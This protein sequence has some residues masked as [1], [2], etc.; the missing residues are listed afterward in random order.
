MGQEPRILVL[1]QGYPISALVDDI[2]TS[3]SDSVVIDARFSDQLKSEADFRLVLHFARDAGKRI[4][5]ITRDPVVTALAGQLGVDVLS[6]LQEQKVVEPDDGAEE[7]AA[8]SDHEEEPG[9]Q[10]E[11]AGEG[12][13]DEA[14]EGVRE[15]AEIR[16]GGAMVGGRG[17][18]RRALIVAAALA[19]VAAGV[20]LVYVL[21]LRVGVTVIPATVNISETVIIA[22][23]PTGRQLGESDVTIGITVPSEVLS[24]EVEYSTEIPTTGE[25]REGITPSVGEVLLINSSL[26]PVTVPARTRL[27]T[28]DGIE[29]ETVNDVTVDPKTITMRAGLKVGEIN[30]TAVVAATACNPGS[31][32]N[33]PAMSIA[34]IKGPLAGRLQVVNEHEFR[35]GRDRVT[36]VVSEADV[37]RLMQI[38]ERWMLEDGAARLR[39]MAGLDRYL[40]TPTLELHIRSSRVYPDALTESDRVS[41]D[42]EG[43]VDLAS[44][45]FRDLSAAIEDKLSAAMGDGFRL[46]ADQL[47][48]DSLSCARLSSGIV[49]ISVDANAAFVAE[50]DGRL[51]AAA[52]AGEPVEDARRRLL[53]SGEVAEFVVDGYIDRFPRWPRLIDVTVAEPAGIEVGLETDAG[54]V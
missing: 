45:H 50:V 4:T 9:E 31:D 24:V 8:P 17:L 5:V 26:D 43:R 1:T 32:G 29:F 37:E 12:I 48:I 40:L 27:S 44:V 39:K 47:Q 52:L 7:P 34:T 3:V 42:I 22:A 14:C 36:R 11:E 46:L 53:E 18:P 25:R 2:R 41:I 51:V 13:P 10:D 35:G 16:R 20:W 28:A 33:V 19:L 23:D 54:E 6:E 21:S 15:G 49:A 30:G 38:S